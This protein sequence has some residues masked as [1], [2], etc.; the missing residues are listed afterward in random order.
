[1][2][3]SKSMAQGCILWLTDPFKDQV[4]D[5][6]SDDSDSEQLDLPETYNGVETGLLGH[7]VMVLHTLEGTTDVAVCL[8]SCLLILH[9]ILLIA[10]HQM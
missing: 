3:T 2:L 4:K 9:T 10:D 1:M 6:G 7:P 5:E 8:V